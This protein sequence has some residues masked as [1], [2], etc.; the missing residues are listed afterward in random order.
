MVIFLFILLPLLAVVIDGMAGFLSRNKR[1][2]FG[3]TRSNDFRVLVPI[4]GDTRYL[5]N[6]NALTGYGSQVTL[7]TTGF[8]SARFYEE[9]RRIADEHGF[10][11]FYDS[12]SEHDRRDGSRRSTGGTTRDRLIRSVLR[13]GVSEEFVIPLDADSVPAGRFDALAGEMKRRKLDLASVRIMPANPRASIL[14]RLQTLEYW[15]AMQIRFV[16]PWMLSGACH[17]ARTEVLTDIM[18]RHSL[19]FQGND[20]ETGLI[21]DARGYKVGHVAFKVLSDVPSRLLP[22]L[23]QRLAWSGGQFRLFIV[24]IRFARWHPFMWL[25]GA[26]VVYILALAFR[27]QL[28]IYPLWHILALG[29]GYLALVL[30]LYLHRGGGKWWALAMLPYVLFVSFVL[31]P[32][33]ILW[34]FK[35]A[36]GA[37]TAGVIRPAKIRP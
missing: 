6:I 27:W 17:A 14:T 13:R 23:R 30:Y 28:S 8:E 35:M 15:I 22:W 29:I 26:G 24:N 33:G 3:S 20:V 11:V 1:Y 21:A 34:Y 19:F 7:C 16:A 25:Y 32:L 2:E 31:V 10:R 18:N 37:G 12:S 4:W 9:L 36:L 5:T